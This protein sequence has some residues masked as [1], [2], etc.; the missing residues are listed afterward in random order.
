MIERRRLFFENKFSTNI[1]KAEQ[2]GFSESAMKKSL[3]QMWHFY[4][5]GKRTGKEYGG[6]IT[7]SGD[8]VEQQLIY[9]RFGVFVHGVGISREQILEISN[10]GKISW[11]SH[12]HGVGYPSDSDK[13]MILKTYKQKLINIGSVIGKFPMSPNILLGTFYFPGK[14]ALYEDDVDEFLDINFV[15]KKRN[16]P[17][18]PDKW[19]LNVPGTARNLR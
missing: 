15:C 9:K 17:D 1:S 10:N 16:N 4:I 3:S 6:Y 8:I 14:D 13:E 19:E 18:N 5:K 12:P 2:L 7:P 11:H